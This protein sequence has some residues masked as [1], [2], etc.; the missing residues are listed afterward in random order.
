MFRN[1]PSGDIGISERTYVENDYESK[2]DT[3]VARQSSSSKGGIRGFEHKTQASGLFCRRKTV[4]ETARRDALSSYFRAYS[5]AFLYLEPSDELVVGRVVLV[6]PTDGERSTRIVVIVVDDFLQ[7]A[8]EQV[9]D[10]VQPPDDQTSLGTVHR[11]FGVRRRRRYCVHRGRPTTSFYRRTIGRRRRCIPRSATLRT[12]RRRVETERRNGGA[13]IR[14]L[15]NKEADERPAR[16]VDDGFATDGQRKIR[17]E[18]RNDKAR[19]RVHGLRDRNQLSSPVRAVG[20]HFR[21]YRLCMCVRVCVC[22]YLTMFVIR[23]RM[24]VI[25]TVYASYFRT[26]ARSHCA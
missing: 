12:A 7:L 9:P 22:V 13:T 5:Y 20:Y 18:Q 4:F 2:S 23:T 15:S 6:Q 24:S 8:P 26:C 10:G 21:V 19:V 1:N 16:H 14:R 17:P 3:D 25:I 11:Q